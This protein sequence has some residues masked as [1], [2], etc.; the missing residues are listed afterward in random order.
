LGREAWF[1]S[2]YWKRSLFGREAYLEEKQKEIKRRLKPMP[3]LLQN[4][5]QADFIAGAASPRQFP[6]PYPFEIAFMGRS[7][8]GKSSTLNR[9]LG[10]KALARVSSQPGRTREINFF[11][12]SWIKGT[13]P[14]LVADLPGYGYARAPG[15]TVRSWKDLVEGYLS[16]ERGQRAALLLDARRDL[17]KEEFTLLRSL[18]ELSIPSVLVATKADKLSRSQGALR[19]RAYRSSL[20]SLSDKVPVL[21][22]S[23]LSGRGKEELLKAIFPGSFIEETFSLGDKGE[24]GS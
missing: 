10:R 3:F 9:F 6:E 4:A 15:K 17:A 19:L 18:E 21:L 12:V 24:P 13:Q 22:F 20:G 8:C 1:L 16:Q 23:A 5:F 11:K 14:F 2:I 7:N